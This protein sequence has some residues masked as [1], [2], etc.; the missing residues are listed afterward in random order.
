MV[1]IAVISL[2]ALVMKAPAELTVSQRDADLDDTTLGV[3]PSSV[4]RVAPS[5]PLLHSRMPQN[6]KIGHQWMHPFPSASSETGLGAGASRAVAAAMHAKAVASRAEESGPLNVFGEKLAG[7]ENEGDLC[8]YTDDSP[9]LCVRTGK[10][11]FRFEC[12]SIWTAEWKQFKTAGGKIMENQAPAVG[13][14]TKC[15]AVPAEALTSPYS[16]K[17]WDSYWMT[18]RVGKGTFNEDGVE[19]IEDQSV[20][21]KS[22]KGRRFRQSIDF[23]CQTCALYA[24]SDA[25]K[26]SLMEKCNKIGWTVENEYQTEAPAVSMFALTSS[27]IMSNLAI[28]LI[29]LSVGSGVAFKVLSFRAARKTKKELLL[30][31]AEDN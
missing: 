9:Q 21:K 13:D 30:E 29:G 12:K 24:E 7:C 14:T 11:T 15:E 16:K 3:L 26:T 31:G 5:N 6:Q 18:A 17:S 22:S 2:F 23:I 27:G 28:V 19:V 20:P 25:A 10:L 8:A 4:A 1:S